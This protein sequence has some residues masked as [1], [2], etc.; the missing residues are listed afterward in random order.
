MTEE[1]KLETVP[2]PSESGE[3][4]HRTPSRVE[5][6]E[7]CAWKRYPMKWDKGSSASGPVVGSP[8]LQPACRTR[9]SARRE[10]HLH[11]PAV[12]FIRGGNEVVSGALSVSEPDIQIDLPALPSAPPVPAAD[13]P[14]PWITASLAPGPLLCLHSC[15]RQ[16]LLFP[17]WGARSCGCTMHLSMERATS[18]PPTAC[19]ICA[20]FAGRAPQNTALVPGWEPGWFVIVKRRRRASDLGGYSM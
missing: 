9:A 5:R 2:R 7:G 8:G 13:L 20:G 11:Y 12:I 17:S 10:S 6:R 4:G 3:P 15:P 18:I 1:V 16:V 14:T 19:L